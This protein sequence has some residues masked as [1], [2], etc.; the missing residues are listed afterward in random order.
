M[1]PEEREDRRTL[2]LAAATILA[3]GNSTMTARHAVEV[4][5]EIEAVVRE[6]H[7]TL[8]R[9]RLDRAG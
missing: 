7:P 3:G 9:Q 8:Y 4:A 1:S 6:C 2:V 5:M